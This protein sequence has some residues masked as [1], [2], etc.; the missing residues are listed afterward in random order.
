MVIFK[1]RC[2]KQNFLME[3]EILRWG[4]FQAAS[5]YKILFLFSS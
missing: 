1:I 3:E 5:L 4:N 2:Y